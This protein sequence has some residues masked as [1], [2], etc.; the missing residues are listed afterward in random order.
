MDQTSVPIEELLT[1]LKGDRKETLRAISRHAVAAGAPQADIPAMR[2][3]LAALAGSLT[4]PVAALSRG[5]S[6]SR[7]LA[8]SGRFLLPASGNAT[9]FEEIADGGWFLKEI[10]REGEWR[11]PWGMDVRFDSID[12][13][14]IASETTRL[15]AQIMRVPVPDGHSSAASATRGW[16]YAFWTDTVPEGGSSRLMALMQIQDEE[17]QKRVGSG[18]RDVSMM[19]ESDYRDTAGNRYHHVVTHI[20]LT[21][22][23]VIDTQTNFEP[24]ELA[25]PGSPPG[26]PAFVQLSR[27][28]ETPSMLTPT[29]KTLA[30]L[31]FDRG[32]KL[33]PE[34]VETKI[35]ELSRQAT[36]ASTERN[37]LAAQVA[38]FS[39]REKARDVAELEQVVR[40]TKTAAAAA[41]RPE[42]FSADSEKSVRR[43]WDA[44]LRDDARAFAR[45]AASAASAPPSMPAAS[46]EA[47]G[48]TRGNATGDAKRARDAVDTQ[49]EAAKSVGWSVEKS[50]DGKSVTLRP[51][52]AAA[53]A[54]KSAI[55]LSYPA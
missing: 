25:V 2:T 36:E 49:I 23:P 50:P 45:L 28:Q 52:A 4:S 17:T 24:L 29:D 48:F 41:G 5:G 9:P 26:A 20:A 46:G 22:Y 1:S 53:K 10:V 47:I 27:G 6:A 40:E 8:L 54:G 18:I 31:G 15:L 21:P 33:T 14:V 39:A 42:L 11:H 38:E 34:Q 43:M 3:R 30:A 19:L 12:I 7:Q 44:G 16:A 37:R 51:N 13:A 35:L 32:A 55:T